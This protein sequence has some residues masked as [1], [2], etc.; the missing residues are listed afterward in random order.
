M[1]F[2]EDE[3][4]KPIA[5]EDIPKDTELF[6]F[7]KVVMDDEGNWD[8]DKATWLPQERWAESHSLSHFHPSSNR[9]FLNILSYFYA[10]SLGSIR[11]LGNP[12]ISV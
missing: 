8:E 11:Y 2:A 4:F 12:I 1:A 10:R 3:S 6:F 7:R 9:Y 5:L